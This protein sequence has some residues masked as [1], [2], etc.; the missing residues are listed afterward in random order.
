[1]LPAIVNTIQK[2]ILLPVPTGALRGALTA[3]LGDCARMRV[4]AMTKTM[5]EDAEE[6][7]RCGVVMCVSETPLSPLILKK[8]VFFVISHTLSYHIRLQRPKRLC[9][10]HSASSKAF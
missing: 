5:D 10:L 2:Q 4:S 6:E 7:I 1:V 9:E 8:P 3:L